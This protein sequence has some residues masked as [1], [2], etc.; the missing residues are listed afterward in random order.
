MR[1]KVIII[2]TDKDYIS[3][4]NKTIRQLRD[5]GLLNV[6]VKEISLKEKTGKS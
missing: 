1:K 4:A 6:E 3:D 2:N 5:R